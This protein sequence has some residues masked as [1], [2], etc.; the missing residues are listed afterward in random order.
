MTKNEFM[1]MSLPYPPLVYSD[2]YPNMNIVTTMTKDFIWVANERYL[3]I[4]WNQTCGDMITNIKPYLRPLS[5]L[6]KTIEINGKKIIPV[7]EFLKIVYYTKNPIT[8]DDGVFDITENGKVITI[9]TIYNTRF[10]FS[11]E[12]NINF[13]LSCVLELRDITTHNHLQAFQKLVEWH[14]DIAN[15]IDKGEAI[16]VNTLTYNPYDSRTNKKIY[17]DEVKSE[18]K[19]NKKIMSYKPIYSW[20]YDPWGKGWSQKDNDL[21][22][23]YEIKCCNTENCGLYAEKKCALIKYSNCPYGNKT[24]SKGK[25]IESGQYVEWINDYKDKHADTINNELESANKMTYV[26]DYVYL[27]NTD[28]VDQRYLKYNA[29]KLRGNFLDKNEFVAEVICEYILRYTIPY[30][31]NSNRLNFWNKQKFMREL[32][33]MNYELFNEVTEYIKQNNIKI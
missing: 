32:K 1:A 16:N 21:S 5:D 13:N 22:M 17:N 27:T 12:N 31:K 7:V 2:K 25:T 11:Y 9:N 4:G 3:K 33:D 29:N 14:F 10:E 28:M 6:T 24:L 15:L 19:T 30:E 23:A 20:I 18:S 8:Y 26:G